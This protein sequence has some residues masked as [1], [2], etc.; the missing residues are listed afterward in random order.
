MY[1]KTLDQCYK[2]PS[3][4]K[5]IIYDICVRKAT[6]DNAVEYGVMSYNG[7]KFTFAYRKPNNEIVVIRPS[8][9]YIICRDV[10]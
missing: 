7:F 1:L 6:K 8:T 2:N 4:S 9:F 3:T 10:M 5:Q